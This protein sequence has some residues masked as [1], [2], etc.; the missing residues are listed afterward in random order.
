M[1]NRLYLKKLLLLLAAVS[2]SFAF[3]SGTDAERARWDQEAR[4]VTIVRDDF[5]I[6]HVFG[7]TDADTVFGSI[8]AQ[9]ED[10]FNRVEMNYI[11]SMG[12]LSETEGEPNIYQDLRMKIFIDPNAMKTQ[13]EASPAWLK[14]LMNSFADGLNYYLYKHPEV[15]P[16]VIKRFEPWMALTFSEGSIGGDIEKVNLRQL[17]AFYGRTP[18]S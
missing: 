16:K 9:A 4:N 12:R 5:G 10:D 6:A 8:Y 13:Y 7:K 3:Q 17:E 1:Q 15:Q 11:E 14:A 18:V 2:A